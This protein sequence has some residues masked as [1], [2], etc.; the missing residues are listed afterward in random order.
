MPEPRSFAAAPHRLLFGKLVVRAL[1]ARRH[2]VAAAEVYLG[3]AVG[4][5]VSAAS[6]GHPR[7]VDLFRHGYFPP[8]RERGHIYHVSGA[9]FLFISASFA[10]FMTY[11]SALAPATIKAISMNTIPRMPPA[12]S[13]VRKVTAKLF[14]SKNR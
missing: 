12:I 5:V 7:L 3:M 4:A 8:A 14:L 6:R 13:F 10:L 9:A 1:G 2:G 11:D